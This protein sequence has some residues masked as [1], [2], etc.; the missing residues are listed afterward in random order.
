MFTRGELNGACAAPKV[1]RL[2]IVLF[3]QRERGQEGFG[4]VI[5]LFIK[6]K[7]GFAGQETHFPTL[8]PVGHARIK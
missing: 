2:N 4:C 5:V 8:S 7:E 1:R 3:I 6:L